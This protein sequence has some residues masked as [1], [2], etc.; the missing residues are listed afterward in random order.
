MRT[1]V[2][3]FSLASSLL[4][5]VLVGSGAVDEARGAAGC[6]SG[7]RKFVRVCIDRDARPRETF[8]DASATCAAIARRLP[9]GAEL[10]AFRQ[11]DDIALF[12]YEW[13]GDII[14]ETTALVMNDTGQYDQGAIHES[15][16]LPF[17]CVK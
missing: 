6:P 7:T 4:L 3:G 9:T 15:V 16:P 2:P 14:D 12:E 13:T 11:Q 10:E 17:R 1:A 5:L 8:R